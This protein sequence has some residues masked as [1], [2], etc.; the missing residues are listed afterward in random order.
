MIE[1]LAVGQVL[2]LRIRYNPNTIAQKTHP[3]L[4]YSLNE[5]TIDLIAIDSAK[6]KIYQLMK[7][8]N[9]YID[10]ENPHETVIYK[11]SYAQLDNKITIDKFE[12]LKNAR[13]T[14]DTLSKKKFE[15]LSKKY[16][17][18]QSNHFIDE[19]KIIYM[20]REEVLEYNPEISQKEV[21]M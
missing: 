20:T 16:E 13:Q 10:T 9:K 2:W 19:S 1:D 3:M 18:F 14:T 12:N 8:S 4:I 11:D 17:E 21:V 5:N 15:E 7:K 6:G